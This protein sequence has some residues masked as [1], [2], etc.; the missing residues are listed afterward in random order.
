[1][2]WVGWAV[3][4][5]LVIFLMPIWKSIWAYLPVVGSDTTYLGYIFLVIGIGAI[6]AHFVIPKSHADWRF[7]MYILMIMSII[8]AI[9]LLFPTW[10]TTVW[11]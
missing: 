7:N 6:V 8:A 5:T 9:E 2:F 1:M 11:F 4:Y 10:F 3:V